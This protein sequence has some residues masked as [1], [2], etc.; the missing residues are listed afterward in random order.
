MAAG[1]IVSFVFGA[2]AIFVYRRLFTRLAIGGLVVTGLL[3]FSASYDWYRF[4]H[5]VHGV[6]DQDEGVVRKGDAETYQPGF[7]EPIPEGT[8]FRVVKQRGKWILVHMS[9]D[10]EGWIPESAA[11]VY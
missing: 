10:Q 4:D 2:L 6:V 3:I 7:T 1:A 11:V 8:G 9:G 5:V